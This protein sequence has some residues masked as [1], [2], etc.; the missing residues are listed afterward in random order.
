MATDL[1]FDADVALDVGALALRASLATSSRRIAVVGPSGA[2]KSTL[3]RMLAG[4]EPRCRGRI[5]FE[6]ECWLKTASG[7]VVP[8]HRRHVG[9]VP[10]DVRLFPHRSVLEN[11]RFAGSTA[12]QARELAVRL[13]VDGLLDRRPRHLSGGEAQRVAIAR[14]LLARPKLLL[15]DEPFAALDRAR[16]VDLATVLRELLGRDHVASVLVSHDERDVALLADEVF[17]MSAGCLAPLSAPTAP[18]PAR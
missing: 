2:G 15:L 13:G 9:W 3:L 16:R 8:A 10:Q 11:L 18:S 6:G 5:S 14:A 4:L 7:T 17:E 1:V 12:A